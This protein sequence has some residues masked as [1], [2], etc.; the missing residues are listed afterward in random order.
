MTTRR[1]FLGAGLAALGSVA[2]RDRSPQRRSPPPEPPAPPERSLVELIVESDRERLLEDLA[3]R[4]A[5][6]TPARLLAALQVAAT[7]HVVPRE[8]FSKEHHVLICG[9]GALGVSGHT[10]PARRWAPALWLVDYFKWAQSQAPARSTLAVEPA[11]AL[12]AS[13]QAARAF[14]DAV[15]SFDGPRA[16]A[17]VVALERAG[18][19]GEAIELLL[20]YGS[21][22]LRHIGHK[23]IYVATALGAA[24]TIGW[25]EPEAVLRS[26][27]MTLAL[28]YQE[29]G[30]DL[31]GA[32]AVSR[33]ESA[34]VPAG[35]PPG[36]SARAAVIE[37]MSILRSAPPPDA[38]RA[39]AAMWRRGTT[40]QSLWDAMTLSSAELMFRHPSSIEALHAVTASN[41][42]GAAY[43]RTG[44]D[45]TRR[46][47]LLQNVARVADFHGYAAHW[48][49][50]R[51]RPAMFDLALE[52][53]EPAPP[54]AADPLADVFAEIG[55][56]AAARM[57]AA[58]KTLGYLTSDATHAARFAAR[59]A[60]TVIAR[61][62][63]THDFKLLAAAL[64]DHS[65][66][67]PE[68]RAHYLAGCTARLRG[69]AEPVT[70][71]GRR[72][73]ALLTSRSL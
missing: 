47:L 56:D 26:I 70:D 45:D 60:D 22:D 30:R 27:A 34:T 14:V 44:A 25:D 19:R 46:L 43:R 61:A 58:G 29:P 55:G 40:P 71:V 31:D 73:D 54:D 48:A 28:H 12:P 42:A 66:L 23:A 53:L 64:E 6:L 8:S 39:A 37:L 36:A 24:D 21:R 4:L 15:E 11:A 13:D 5:G 3:P 2:C 32:W 67:S 51:G 49:V 9:H 57:R 20:R 38:V 62:A 17:A 69:T 33:A 52:T 1:F 50:K 41:A 65:H 10:A 35:T 18:R 63:D 16:E 68:W 7:R 59:A 72:I